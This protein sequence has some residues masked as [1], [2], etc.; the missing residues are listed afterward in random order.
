MEAVVNKRALE[1]RAMKFIP[2]CLL[3]LGAALVHAQ[4]PGSAP[5]SEKYKKGVAAISMDIAKKNL[6]YLSIDCEGRGTR[7]PG[8]QK[9]A[10]YMAARFK[11]AG[12]KP[13][14]DNGTYFQGVPFFRTGIDA[15]QS[16]IATED[17]STKVLGD[18]S[19]S[20]GRLGADADKSAQVIFIR[21]NGMSTKLANVDQLNGK[22]VFLSSNADSQ[23]L[24]R[25]IR[26]AT[27]VAVIRVQDK[28]TP[29][30]AGSVRLSRGG[31][32]GGST[33]LNF[34]S[35]SKSGADRLCRS[36]PEDTAALD[37]SN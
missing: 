14:G 26:Q 36:L 12:L 28:V 2:V 16:Y 25:Q 24:M 35:I 20:F 5:I 6:T 18:T 11:E 4:Y 13:V 10:E 31:R 33:S 37:P 9:A 32:G 3:A 7:Q 23:E 29:A 19:I 27:T 8:F 1:N 21:A 34:M 15:S 17:G 22:I 30:P